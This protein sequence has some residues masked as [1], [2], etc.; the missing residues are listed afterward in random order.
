[1][2]NE[3]DLEVLFNPNAVAIFGASPNPEKINGRSLSFLKQYEYQGGI[4]PINPK[5]DEVQGIRC[6]KNIAEVGQQVDMAVISV[7]AELVM[8]ILNECHENGVKSAIIFSSGFAET[9]TDEGERLQKELEEFIER[10]GLLVCGPNCIGLFNMETGLTPTFT[11]ALN[12]RMEAITSH[13]GFVTQSGAFGVMIYALIR[14][15]GHDFR[16][17]MNTGNEAGVEFSDAINYMA[18]D[19]GIKVISGYIEGIKDGDKF[20]RAADKA[21]ENGK[22]LALLKVGT[23]SVGQ[24]A[25]ASHTGSLAGSDVV[26]DSVFKQHGALR[27][28]DVN[29]LKNFLTISAQPKVPN[30]NR[31]GIITMS[32]GAGVL[33]AD[34]CE[35]NGLETPS[36]SEKT[37]SELKDI[38]PSFG[39]SNNPVDTT[40]EIINSPELL[41]KCLEIMA[42]DEN[43]DT[44]VIFLGLLDHIKDSLVETLDDFNRNT[45]KL[46]SIIWM[47]GPENVLNDLQSVQ[48]P[49]FDDPTDAITSISH[50]T[51][52]GK[53][54]KSYKKKKH[55]HS[56]D[57][58]RKKKALNYINEVRSSGT[59]SLSEVQSKHL[60]EMYNLP[61]NTIK[62]ARAHEEAV[63]FAKEISFPVVMKIESPSILHK[64]DIGG[65]ELNIQSP[66][67][68]KEAFEKIKK[69]AYKHNPEIDFHGI[70]VQK[71]E[72]PGLEMIIGSNYDET[73]GQIGMLGIGG[74]LVEILK[75][76]SLKKFPID[77]QDAEMMLDELTNVQILDGVRGSEAKDKKALVDLIVKLSKMINE[78]DSEIQS[79]DINPL[80]LYEE[81]K[82]L[83]IV[84]GLIILK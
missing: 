59:K 27:M 72:K 64:T 36:L 71:M 38:L 18:E 49:A 19:E 46:V 26:Y 25:A 42:H 33:I 48:V 76:F 82:G 81:N 6:Y 41:T 56:I 70:S 17:F 66:D 12:R 22:P 15:M 11:T 40:A 62:L 39:T 61:V 73:F 13:I 75:D 5:Y 52:F 79:I 60:F 20:C 34:L 35:E 21:M 67:E 57:Q 32:G 4:Y 2:K 54:L 1:M 37:Q 80:F 24:R 68:V 29:E 23:S 58:D 31:I 44:I 3:K 7:R 43:V 63:A 45:E 84:D 47:A 16:L 30:G 74:V 55:T 77:I 69:N 83:A 78:L 53:N 51:T 28:K 65:V 10:T 14:E 9:H 50:L 8:K